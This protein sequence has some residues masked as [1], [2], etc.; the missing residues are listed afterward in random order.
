MSEHV[1]TSWVESAERSDF[2]IQ[3]LPLG[4]FS[5]G[6]GRRPG[7]A[8]GD[9]VLDLAGLADLLDEDWRTDLSQPVLNAWLARGQ[10]AQSALR[11]RLAELLGDDRHRDTVEPALIGQSEVRMHV[12]CLVGDYTDFYVGIHHAANVGK[13]FRPD[14]PLLPNYK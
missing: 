11:V 8:I 2:P 10:G 4:I 1:Q 5:D 3:N 14:N 6:A 9:F 13:Q 12:P 7:I